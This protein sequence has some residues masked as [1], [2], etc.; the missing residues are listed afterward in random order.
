MKK[1][2]MLA[3]LAS[4]LL[5]S[6]AMCA[7]VADVMLPDSYEVDGK[8]LQL[9]GTALRKKLVIKVYAGAFYTPFKISEL[10]KALSPD[11]PK[12]IRMH[13]IY[14]KVEGEKIIDGYLKIYK[15]D[16]FDYENS[17]PAKKFFSLFSFD[18]VEGDTVD[19]VFPGNS[20]IGLLYNGKLLGTVKSEE[21]C[22]ATLKAYL[23]EN[24]LKSLREGF[25]PK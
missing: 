16:G 20:E 18:A 25:L 9:N 23:G 24:A 17:E 19:L 7:T 14:K 4:L 10:E 12:V 8:S 22:V 1:F 15:K 11:I 3:I 6:Y 13:F 2:S 21:L 5:A